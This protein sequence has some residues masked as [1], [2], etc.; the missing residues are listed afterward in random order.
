[1]HGSGDGGV[2][3]WY[4]GVVESSFGGDWCSGCVGCRRAATVEMV[5]GGNGG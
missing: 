5:T 1:S 4:G 2:G 3:L